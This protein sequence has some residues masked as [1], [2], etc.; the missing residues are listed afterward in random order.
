[1]K[2]FVELP[3]HTFSVLLFLLTTTALAGNCPER[4]T[5]E[6]YCDEGHYVLYPKSLE[7]TDGVTE[8]LAQAGIDSSGVFP[9]LC[10]LGLATLSSIDYQGEAKPEPAFFSFEVIAS[11]TSAAGL[12]RDAGMRIDLFKDTE[13]FYGGNWMITVEG[14]VASDLVDSLRTNLIAAGIDTSSLHV[15]EHSELLAFGQCLSKESAHALEQRVHELDI[16]AVVVVLRYAP[17]DM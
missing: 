6:N 16:E 15:R 3:V 1:M 2:L 9:A 7:P 12:L 11:D 4:E 10:S 17:F 14:A 5:V 13:G 8:A